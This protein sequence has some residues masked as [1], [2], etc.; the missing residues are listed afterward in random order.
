VIGDSAQQ[1]TFHK[2]APLL[3]S[4]I[5]WLYTNGI[6]SGY[7]TETETDEVARHGNSYSGINDTKIYNL[8]GTLQ[9]ELAGT[10]VATR[11][12]P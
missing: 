3:L 9:V 6:L 10:V 12:S 11:I 1:G 7:F 8:N 5:G 4:H 2:V